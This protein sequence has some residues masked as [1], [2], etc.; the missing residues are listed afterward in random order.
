MGDY[1]NLKWRHITE[2]EFSALQKPVLQLVK[3]KGQE[4]VV[5]VQ[6]WMAI[7]IY[8]R[9]GEMKKLLVVYESVKYSRQYWRQ[10]LT[11]V[12]SSNNLLSSINIL[13][14][15]KKKPMKLV[16]WNE[17]FPSKK[18]KQFLTRFLSL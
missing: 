10:E 18:F 16:T 2:A 14:V 17:Q 13:T 12:I 9:H 7:A 4:G 15:K 1:L 11:F 3:R 5:H 8:C 6:R